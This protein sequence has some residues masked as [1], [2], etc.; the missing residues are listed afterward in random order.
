MT[1]RCP[2]PPVPAPGDERV[3]AGRMVMA[4][5]REDMGALKAA[6]LDMH[7]ITKREYNIHGSSCFESHVFT[8]LAFIAADSL[9]EATGDDRGVAD[10]LL[11]DNY[12]AGGVRA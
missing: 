5:L 9:L 8:C 11:L 3:I 2:T 4:A 10:D 1:H 7:N 6:G 12:I